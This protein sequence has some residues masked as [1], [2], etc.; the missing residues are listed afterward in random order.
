MSP[1]RQSAFKLAIFVS[2]LI[3]CSS[4]WLFIKGRLS[5]SYCD[6]SEINKTE[7]DIEAEIGK[8]IEKFSIKEITEKEKYSIKREIEK[9]EL[10]ALPF[11]LH[12]LK[13]TN[14]EE[15]QYYYLSIITEIVGRK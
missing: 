11:L 6:A 3:S 12:V 5:L 4:P 1:T 13:E 15:R 14:D 10:K 2:F 8:L 9:F 7:K